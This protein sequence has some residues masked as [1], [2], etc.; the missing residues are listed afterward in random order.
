MGNPALLGAY[1]SNVLV[2]DKKHLQTTVKTI[3]LFSAFIYSAQI[4]EHLQQYSHDYSLSIIKYSAAEQLHSPACSKAW[5]GV[6]SSSLVCLFVEE[7]VYV[8]LC[9]L[10]NKK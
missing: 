6:F 1:L 7:G 2:C 4:Q 10:K 9:Y 5:W 3:K 8:C